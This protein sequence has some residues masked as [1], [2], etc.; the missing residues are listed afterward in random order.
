MPLYSGQYDER[1]RAIVS[2]YAAPHAQ[3]I[4]MSDDNAARA[5]IDT[6]S[7]ITCLSRSLI[8]KLKLRPRGKTRL[9]TAGGEVETYIYSIVVCLPIASR[10]QLVQQGQQPPQVVPKEVSIHT[11]TGVLACGFVP[12]SADYEVLLGTDVLRNYIFMSQGRDFVVG[13]GTDAGPSVSDDSEVLTQTPP[14][15]QVH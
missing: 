11:S 15:H 10:P 2:V 5:L 7:G 8:D 9:L 4:E 14:P 3:H 6:A 1:R 13:F 12:R